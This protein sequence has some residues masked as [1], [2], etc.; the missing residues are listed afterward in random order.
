MRRA[1]RQAPSRARR[2]TGS[3]VLRDRDRQPF[4]FERDLVRVAPR[5]VLARLERKHDRMAVLS[6]VLAGVAVRRGG[7]AAGPPPRG[8]QPPGPPPGTRREAPRT[9]PS[10]AP[11]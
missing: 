8:G 5:P 9:A 11:R 7:A 4:D 3:V 10:G 2:G 1:T 6:G